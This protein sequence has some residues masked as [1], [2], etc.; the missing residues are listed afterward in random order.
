M[1]NPNR[2][3]YKPDAELDC[4]PLLFVA[5][6]RK[7]KIIFVMKSDKMFQYEYSVIKNDGDWVFWKSGK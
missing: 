5:K 2:A 3:I 1:R 7:G 4:G 6:K